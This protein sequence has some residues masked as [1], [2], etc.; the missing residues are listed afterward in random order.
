MIKKNPEEIELIKTW[1]N[2][3][4]ENLLSAQILI[5]E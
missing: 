2:L 5:D 1:L 3:A 4:K